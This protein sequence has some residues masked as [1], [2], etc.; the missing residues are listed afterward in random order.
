VAYQSDV[1]RWVLTEPAMLLLEL[2]A[3]TVDLRLQADER[4]RRA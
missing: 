3:R 2:A 4:E 1:G